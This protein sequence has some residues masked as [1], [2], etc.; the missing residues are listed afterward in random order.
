MLKALTSSIFSPYLYFRFLTW[1]VYSSSLLVFGGFFWKQKQAHI[2]CTVRNCNQKRKVEK[3]GFLTKR[4]WLR[5]KHISRW[6][7]LYC[8]ALYTGPSVT[9][10]LISSGLILYLH[11]CIQ[12]RFDQNMGLLCSVCEIFSQYYVAELGCS[13]LSIDRECQRVGEWP[14]L[15]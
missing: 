9:L 15:P 13:A 14:P 2:H 3:R 11:V 4:I 12:N 7:L 5:T 10:Q 8:T 6:C 1:Q